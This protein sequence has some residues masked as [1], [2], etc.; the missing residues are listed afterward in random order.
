[1][2]ENN[3]YAISI[4]QARHQAI[5]DI[6]VRAAGY[7][8]PGVSVDG[9]DPL[10]VYEAAK[11]AVE[12]ARRGE[13]PSLIE[14]KTYRHGGHFN[15]DPAR[16][17]PQEEVDEWLKKDPLPRFISYLIDNK[18]FTKEELEAFDA[19][20]DAEI[21]E[22]IAFADEQPYAPVESTVEDVYSDII[23]EVRNR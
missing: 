15:G 4:S 14:C 21:K 11:E 8:M 7:N 17:R 1:V 19:Q 6:S 20:V 3:L 10:A 12:R 2:C 5:K 9:N 22:A 13:G 18:H 16:Y 23:E